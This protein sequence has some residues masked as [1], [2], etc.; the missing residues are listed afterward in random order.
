MM[1]AQTIVGP[2]DRVVAVT[3]VWPNVMEIPRILAGR[4]ETVALQPR[5]AAGGWISTSCSRP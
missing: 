3:P 5:T 2:G 4:V 1:A